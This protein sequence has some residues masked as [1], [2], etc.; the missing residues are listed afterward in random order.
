MKI[1]LNYQLF[2]VFFCLE[3]WWIMRCQSFI[4]DVS[5]GSKRLMY[6][7]W[8]LMYK[9]RRLMYKYRRLMY[10]YY[11]ELRTM[12]IPI[13]IDCHLNNLIVRQNVIIFV[14]SFCLSR[15]LDTNFCVFKILICTRINLSI[16]WQFKKS[17]IRKYYICII[18]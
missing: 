8:R 18:L 6:K 15:Y 9:N 3:G 1:F 14:K 7:Y 5:C 17:V 2:F 10:N 13:S 11:I 16:T 12:P 4:F